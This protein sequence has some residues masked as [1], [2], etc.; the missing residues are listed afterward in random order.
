[1]ED[2]LNTRM[3]RPNH[4]IKSERLRHGWSQQELADQ[5]GTTLTNV[6]R[7]E[8]GVTV[9]RLYFRSRLCELLH[10]SPEDLGFTSLDSAVNTVS[11]PDQ[12]CLPPLPILA[13]LCPGPHIHRHLLV[14]QLLHQLDSETP[15]SCLALSGLAGAGKTVLAARVLKEPALQK[16]FEGNIFWT[17]LGPQPALYPLLLQWCQAL[18]LAPET[19]ADAHTVESLAMILNQMLRQSRALFLI[20]DVWR[21]EDAQAFKV[22][23]NESCYLITTRFPLVGLQF[24]AGHMLTAGAFLREES[25]ELLSHLLS[26]CLSQIG[27]QERERLIEVSGGHP[28]LLHLIARHL[29]QV[30]FYQQPRRLQ[31]AIE[32]LCSSAF[33]RLS[34]AYPLSSIE[35][36]LFSFP[37]NQ[38]TVYQLLDMSM[39]LLDQAACA[40]LDAL[41]GFPPKPHVFSEETALRA[42]CAPLDVLD[43][44]SDF[45]FL[46]SS[47][48]GQ[49]CIQ[50]V[51]ADFASAHLAKGRETG[52]CLTNEEE[53]SQK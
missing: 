30:A 46:E 9:P 8:R 43:T 16:R 2:K 42:I 50:P 18:H 7:W 45:G 32:Q 29:R 6:S 25:V 51:I 34:L 48:S 39:S 17:S 12:A 47:S 23:G 33:T 41:A 10:K 3:C 5:L 13:S 52:I 11:S 35:K 44:L 27:Q 15:P 20:D 53:V 40:A 19:Y 49:Y 22:G 1:M 31:N 21:V 4:Q 28:L 37:G 24:A 14:S 38:M 36:A 26:P